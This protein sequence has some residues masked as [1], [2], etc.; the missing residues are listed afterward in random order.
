MP[1]A[2]EVQCLDVA[3]PRPIVQLLVSRALLGDSSSPL[4]PRECGRRGLGRAHSEF[5]LGP[6]C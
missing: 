2:V 1:I 3:F 4:S 5:V 6:S